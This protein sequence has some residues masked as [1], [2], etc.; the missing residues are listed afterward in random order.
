MQLSRSTPSSPA[1]RSSSTSSSTSSR[2][3]ARRASPRPCTPARSASRARARSSRSTPG[4]S[5]RRRTARRSSSA[6]RRGPSERTLYSPR[7]IQ[8]CAEQLR[9]FVCEYAKVCNPNLKVIASAGSPEKIAILKEIGVDV[10]FNYKEQDTA[11]VLREHG[12]I[13]MYAAAFRLPAIALTCAA[14]T[15]TTSA[16]RRSTPRSSTWPDRKSVV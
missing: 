11:A 15:G 13:D 8:A 6:A 2:S 16:A 10:P 4:A 7:A 14:A 12:P 3:T 9:S 1:P 5:Q